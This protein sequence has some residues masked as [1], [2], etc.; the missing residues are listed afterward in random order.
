MEQ[1]NK[2][3]ITRNRI[4]GL[5]VPFC[6]VL[7]SLTGCY[8]YLS[9]FFDKIEL[10][11]FLNQFNNAKLDLPFIVLT[12]MG[13]GVLFP[14]FA[15][16]FSNRN[17]RAGISILLT[18]FVIL[19]AAG[20]LKNFVFPD[21]LRPSA[22]LEDFVYKKAE[23]FTLYTNHSFPS[24]H[25]MSAFGFCTVLALQLNR[26]LSTWLLALLAVLMAYSRVYLNQHFMVD[27]V[28]GSWIGFILALSVYLWSKTWKSSFWE[29]KLNLSKI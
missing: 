24:G 7:V 12:K 3:S 25:A 4:I 9:S 28:V 18:G 21:Y 19:L 6:L 14:V 1:S 20:L 26:S 15:L 16:F 2:Q 5:I 11:L 13:S 17:Y 10:H 27:I 29:R 23:G 22:F 8:F